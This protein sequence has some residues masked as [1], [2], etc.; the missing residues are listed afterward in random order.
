M[1]FI[2]GPQKVKDVHV[3]MEPLID[4][5]DM[6]WRDGVRAYDVS[7]YGPDKTFTL[8]AMLL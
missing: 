1:V 3:Y 7:S 6:L 5:L 2:I 4:E 8:R